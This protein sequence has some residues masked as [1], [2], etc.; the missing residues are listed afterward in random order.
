M[1]VEATIGDMPRVRSGITDQD[2]AWNDLFRQCRNRDWLKE[3]APDVRRQIRAALV[4]LNASELDRGGEFVAGRNEQCPELGGWVN[5]STRAH[6]LSDLER[7]LFASSYAAVRGKS[8]TLSDFP[9]SLLP[10]HGNVD[11]ALSGGLFSD[12][13][14]VQLSH[15]PSMTITSHISKDGHYYIHP[16]ATQCRSLTVREAA[17]LQTFPEDYFFCGPRTAQYHQVGN[18]VP[19]RLARQIAALILPRLA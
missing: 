18:A 15:R 3:V 12:R 9:H 5:H 17:R 14:R 16:D 11:R 13:F 19:P 1:F 10:N 6:I 8:P 4:A 2:G 7:Y